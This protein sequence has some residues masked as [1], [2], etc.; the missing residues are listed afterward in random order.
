MT[1]LASRFG[2]SRKSAYRWRDRFL[3]GGLDALQDESRAPKTCPHKT[4]P[5]VAKLLVEARSR[6]PHWGARTLPAIVARQHPHL[7][8]PSHAAAHQILRH[9]GLIETKS[10][11]RAKP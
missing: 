3:E 5:A 9:A 1:E 2:V 10:R 8:L 7:A 11:R 4:D 6:H